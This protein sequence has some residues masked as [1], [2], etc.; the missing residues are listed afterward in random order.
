MPSRR[1]TLAQPL[2]RA[3]VHILDAAR[4]Q[5]G[6]ERPEEEPPVA[7]VRAAR[8]R[9]GLAVAELETVDPNRPHLVRAGLGAAACASIDATAAALAA[10]EDL[11]AD[12]FPASAE[13]GSR[14]G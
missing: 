10:C 1:F 4:P 3:V 14:P 5:A 12:P 7:Q 2:L 13:G 6:D 11:G 8:D 9:L